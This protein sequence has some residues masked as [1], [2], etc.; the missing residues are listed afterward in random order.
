M[1]R[2]LFNRSFCSSAGQ[3]SK[4]GFTLIELLLIIVLLGVLAVAAI[5]AFEGNEDQG[6]EN[7]TR[8]EMVQL[9]KALLQFR[10]DTRELPC[11]VYLEGVYSP[12][13]DM[14]TVYTFVSEDPALETNPAFPASLEDYELWCSDS[15]PGQSPPP[16][17]PP[18][19]V[20][21]AENALTMLNQFPYD[22]VAYD[23]FYWEASRQRGWNGP[24][25]SK[26]ALKDGWGRPYKLLNPELTY[27]PRYRCKAEG[28]NKYFINTE[29]EFD[30]LPVTAIPTAEIADYILPA[31]IAR[32]VSAGKD[33]IFESLRVESDPSPANDFLYNPGEFNSTADPC[34][35][36][37]NSDDLV[38]CL[39]R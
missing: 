35:P 19:D 11:W 33:G 32:V 34:A 37:E 15:L 7:I 38:L 12:N 17:L 21:Q 13:S 36:A 10:R 3:Q 31:D 20:I 5:N 39:L 29:N 18:E 25:V 24:Y 6:R 23:A 1:R 16:N 9:Q 2:L 8:L 22:D 26:E 30:C 4:S 28:G 14:E 27:G